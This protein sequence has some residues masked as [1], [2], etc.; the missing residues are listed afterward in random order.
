[1][2]EKYISSRSVKNT[3]RASITYDKAL[4]FGNVES[5][6]AMD[7]ESLKGL[8]AGLVSSRNG[9]GGRAYVE[10]LKNEATYP[11]FDWHRVESYTINTHGGARTGAGRKRE[12][13]ELK[14][15]VSASVSAES[16]QKV[17]DLYPKRG[18]FGKVLDDFIK[19][20]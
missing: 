19:T 5:I 10:I 14:Q 11:S 6:G 13:K 4:D 15:M 17:K 1:M 7:I 16:A 8:V 9:K 18:E 3:Y 12:G 2:A 20:L